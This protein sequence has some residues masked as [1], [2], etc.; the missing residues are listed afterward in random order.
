MLLLPETKLFDEAISER[1]GGL[2]V[3]KLESDYE[4]SAQHD[5]S[6]RLILHVLLPSLLRQVNLVGR[7]SRS[8]I[9]H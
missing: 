1:L 2:V 6:S 9:Q 4:A 7:R 8:A 3:K 5:R